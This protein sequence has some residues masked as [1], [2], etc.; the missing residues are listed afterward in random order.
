M[1]SD[2]PLHPSSRNP[3]RAMMTVLT[4]IGGSVLLGLVIGW[5]SYFDRS[6]RRKAIMVFAAKKEAE[7][8][9]KADVANAAELREAV[10]APE[11]TDGQPRVSLGDMAKE[12][13]K[14]AD[15][16]AVPGET[17]TITLPLDPNSPE[18]QQADELLKNYTAAKTWQE[19]IP[20]VY[21]PDRT[22]VLMEHFYEVQK[23]SDPVSGALLNRGHYRLDGTEILHFTYSCNRP[24]DMLELAMRRSA[25]GRFLLDWT[26]YVGFSQMSW[27]QF[28][29]ERPTS[30]VLFRAFATSSDYYNYEFAD[31]KKYLSLN[32]LSPDGL[33][34]MHGFCERDTPLGGAL[35]RVLARNNSMSGLVLRLAFPERAE[36]DHCVWIRQFVSDR[37]LVLP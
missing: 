33:L 26:S 15:I 11:P 31:P 23:A 12:S 28:K 34:S 6:S 14:D 24:G 1:E 27:D 19:K 36:S 3:H 2:P 16:S 7:L 5:Q 20:F 13:R 18:V 8:K 29:K 9:L 37:W 17:V 10:P 22:R 25:D 35:A 30:A 21:Q 32:L 4:M